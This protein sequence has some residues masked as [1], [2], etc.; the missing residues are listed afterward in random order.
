MVNVMQ[1]LFEKALSVTLVFKLALETE[2]TWHRLKGAQT[3]PS[4]IGGKGCL[5]SCGKNGEFIKRVCYAIHKI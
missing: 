2:K 3:Y 4:C 5:G 1:E